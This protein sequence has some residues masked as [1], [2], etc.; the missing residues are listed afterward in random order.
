M[1]KEAAAAAAAAAAIGMNEWRMEKEKNHLKNEVEARFFFFF[2]YFW[3]GLCEALSCNRVQHFQFN[4]W[5]SKRALCSVWNVNWMARCAAPIG[6]SQQKA[7]SKGYRHHKRITG[8]MAGKK[9]EK[10]KILCGNSS[11]SRRGGRDG[12]EYTMPLSQSSSHV[13]CM[14]VCTVHECWI[15]ESVK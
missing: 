7:L 8:W 9:W 1:S 13:A 2:L 4:D 14:C 10:E 6:N 11:S 5:K 3:F 15:R 12:G